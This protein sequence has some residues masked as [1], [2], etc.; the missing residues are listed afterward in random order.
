MLLPG[1]DMTLLVVGASLFCVGAPLSGI[2]EGLQTVASGMAALTLGA[3]PWTGDS[4][5]NHP[6]VLGKTKPVSCSCSQAGS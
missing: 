3:T 2:S 5:E 6:I 1:F 4:I